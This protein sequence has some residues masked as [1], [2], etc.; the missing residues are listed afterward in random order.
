M[1]QEYLAMEFPDSPNALDHSKQ[2]YDWLVGEIDTSQHRSR[3]DIRPF[4]LDPIEN[5]PSPLNIDQPYY[6]PVPTTV[7]HRR[8]I[9]DIAAALVLLPEDHAALLEGMKSVYSRQDVQEHLAVGG[10]VKFIDSHRTYVGQ[11]MQQIVSWQAQD[12]LNIQNPESRQ[13]TIASRLVSLFK[14][15]IIPEFFRPEGIAD[16]GGMILE[17]ILLRFGAGL[18]TIP[19]SSS[20]NRIRSFVEGGHGIRREA[21]SR[22]KQGYDILIQQGTKIMFEGSSGTENKP[23]KAEN[24]MVIGKVTDRTIELTTSYNQDRDNPRVMCIPVFMECLPFTG[25]P[26]RPIEASPT[27]FAILEPV[28]AGSHHDFHRMMSK[29]AVIGSHLRHSGR[30]P[31]RYEHRFFGRKL[32]DTIYAHAA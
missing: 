27:P 16:H 32:P 17:D 13:I 14:L 7:E 9:A 5:Y 12:Q 4:S 28:F 6:E 1:S 10:V 8:Y 31:Y 19:N 21:V 18:L 20:G 23:N 25:D 15:G 29:I 11:V 2:V 3:F 24:S 26:K 30:L 22:T